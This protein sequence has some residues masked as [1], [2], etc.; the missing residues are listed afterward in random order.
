MSFFAFPPALYNKISVGLGI[1]VA[2]GISRYWVPIQLGCFIAGVV[3]IMHTFSSVYKRYKYNRF[4][5]ANGAILKFVSGILLV[6]INYV[7]GVAVWF[8][9]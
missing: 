6:N 8:V 7:V 2:E 5:L 9:T 1:D 4:D 3:V